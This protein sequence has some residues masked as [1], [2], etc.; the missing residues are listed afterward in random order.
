MIAVARHLLVIHVVR[1]KECMPPVTFNSSAEL[2][3]CM[4]IKVN[5]P[6]EVLIALGHYGR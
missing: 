6:N 5:D 2:W 1:P 4:V 3:W